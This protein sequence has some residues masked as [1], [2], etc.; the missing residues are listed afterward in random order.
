[1]D[2]PAVE[3]RES[4][5]MKVEP[6]FE[7]NIDVSHD[8]SPFYNVTW[9]VNNQIGTSKHLHDYFAFTRII[10]SLL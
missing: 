6:K 1:M 5:L 7:N 4:C 9:S 8:F 2:N 3:I 10:C